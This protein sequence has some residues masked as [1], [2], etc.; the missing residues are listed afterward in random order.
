MSCPADLTGNTIED[1]TALLVA[2]VRRGF[3][4]THPRDANGDLLAVQGVR[5]HDN[6]I[7]V[8]VI[9][10]EHEAKAVR[11]PGDEPDIL[12]P[13]TT[14][15]SWAGRAYTVLTELLAQSDESPI[16]SATTDGCWVPTQAGRAVWL[17]ASTA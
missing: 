8:V 2:L 7:D 1:T 6:V 17:R 9:R 10:A 14:L 15:M 12:R 5:V 16:R 3:K 11:M 4:F 13:T